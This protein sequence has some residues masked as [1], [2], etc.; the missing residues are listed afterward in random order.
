MSQVWQKPFARTE[1]STHNLMEASV[2]R[3]RQSTVIPP[4]SVK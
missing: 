1:A 2:R 4:K 3:Q